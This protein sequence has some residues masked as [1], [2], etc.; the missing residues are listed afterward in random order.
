MR[1]ILAFVH[2]EKAAGT[3]LIH[4][5]RRNYLFRHMDIRPFYLKQSLARWAPVFDAHDLKLV[6]KINPLV[7]C[8]AGHSISPVTDFSAQ[9]NMHYITLLR[10]PIDRYLSQFFYS[11]EYRE[12]T[13]DFPRF[14]DI[15]QNH[16]FQVKKIAGCDDL[17]MAKQILL[18]QFLAVGLVEY[19]DEFLAYLYVVLKPRKKLNLYYHRA[20]VRRNRTGFHGLHQQYL[21]AIKERNRND[22]KLY[23]FVQDQILTSRAPQVQNL[24]Q[25]GQGLFASSPPRRAN[26]ILTDLC[27]YLVRKLYFDPLSDFVRLKNGLARR[28]SY[29]TPRSQ[30]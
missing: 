26:L 2:I 10:D 16:N 5:L 21:S 7:A 6:L 23:Q 3:T 18:N 30:L 8:I 17:E 22:L 13:W 19:F 20:N 24:L 15:E 27:D 9:A 11:R 1:D 28:G 4:I 12:K 14:L 29:A 25:P